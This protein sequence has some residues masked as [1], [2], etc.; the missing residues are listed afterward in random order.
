MLAEL[1]DSNVVDVVCWHFIRLETPKV[2]ALLA[3]RFCSL[4]QEHIQTM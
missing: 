1:S 2:A 3:S 4:M